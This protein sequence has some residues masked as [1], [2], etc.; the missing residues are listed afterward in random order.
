[1]ISS[2][3]VAFMD[4][5]NNISKATFNLHVGLAAGLGVSCALI[6][7]AILGAY[8]AM[9][10]FKKQMKANPPI[11]EQQIR[12]MYGQLGRKPSEKQIRQIMNQ[13]KQSK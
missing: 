11:T 3:M 8:F 9:R 12:F 4:S 6:V 10:I 2:L 13:F 5:N 7:G 1:M